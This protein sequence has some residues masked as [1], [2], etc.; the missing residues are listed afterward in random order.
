[1]RIFYFV[2]REASGLEY[3]VRDDGQQPPEGTVGRA[4]ADAAVIDS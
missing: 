4:C 1:M 2:V 3:W